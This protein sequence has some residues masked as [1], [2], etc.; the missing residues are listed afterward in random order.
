MGKH[1]DCYLETRPCRWHWSG[2]LL[3]LRDVCI[4]VRV[5]LKG[6]LDCTWRDSNTE[7]SFSVRREDRRTLVT[8]PTRPA[9]H[10][11]TVRS[12]PQTVQFPSENGPHAKA[13]TKRNF[14][15]PYSPSTGVGAAASTGQLGTISTTSKK[16]PQEVT[17]QQRQ[18]NFRSHLGLPYTQQAIAQF[19]AAPYNDG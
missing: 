5:K 6:L 2:R 15:R 16:T 4:Q 1:G 8:G 17:V 7:L 11:A 13:H 12:D 18:A 9:I 3:L 10:A 14:S 19:Q